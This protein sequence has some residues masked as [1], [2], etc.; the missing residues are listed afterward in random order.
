M[1][2]MVLKNCIIFKSNK[3]EDIKEEITKYDKEK[4]EVII[5]FSKTGDIILA[6]SNLNLNNIYSKKN[7]KKQSIFILSNVE[8]TKY[9]IK[10][11]FNTLRIDDIKYMQSKNLMIK[12]NNINEEYYLINK[13]SYDTDK[14]FQKI[15]AVVEEINR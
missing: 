5:K 6:I 8:I 1:N 10:K 13:K 9:K 7:L 11:N 14:V 3:F 12:K 4:N 2:K 15:K